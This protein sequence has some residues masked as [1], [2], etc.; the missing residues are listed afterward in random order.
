[1]EVDSRLLGKPP[2]FHGRDDEWGDWAFQTRAYLDCLEEGMPDALDLI[3]ATGDRPLVL[4]AMSPANQAN[5]RKV[6]YV[7]AQLLR[8]HPLLILR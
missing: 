6:Y 5:S 4:T 3:E 2:P 1:M 7:L 8:G